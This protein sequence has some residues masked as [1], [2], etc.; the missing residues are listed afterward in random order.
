MPPPNREKRRALHAN[1]S[2]FSL[3]A[4]L[5]DNG[6]TRLPPLSLANEQE[7]FV[8]ALIAIRSI[9]SGNVRTLNYLIAS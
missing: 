3:L 8:P 5:K 2:G 1:S 9:C 6:S 7:D 4:P